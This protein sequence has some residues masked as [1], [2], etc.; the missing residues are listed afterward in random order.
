MGEPFGIVQIAGDVFLPLSG[1]QQFI[2][3]GDDIG[4]VQIIYLAAAVVAVSSGAVQSAAQIDHCGVGV[5][6]QIVLYFKSQIVLPH[7][8]LQR[9]E[10]LHQ[11]AGVLISIRKVIV[12][13]VNQP[14]RRFI[15]VEIRIQL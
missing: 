15:L 7:G 6:F 9:A 3:H 4:K 13:F 5:D 14:H 11:T 10:A 1:G 12:D 2:A 8:N